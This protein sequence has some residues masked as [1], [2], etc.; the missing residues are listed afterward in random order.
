MVLS[1]LV[2]GSLDNFPSQTLSPL[3]ILVKSLWPP[4]S[5]TTHGQPL[6]ADRLSS[7]G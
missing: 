7:Y 3:I 4:I 2:A 5:E 1:G 6:M